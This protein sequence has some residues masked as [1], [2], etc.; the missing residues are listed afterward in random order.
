MLSTKRMRGAKTVQLEKSKALCV[1]TADALLG[2]QRQENQKW[3]SVCS[4]FDGFTAGV[5]KSWG[6]DASFS[7]D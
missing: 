5:V 3:R 1:Q 6:R 4:C 7:E 2:T